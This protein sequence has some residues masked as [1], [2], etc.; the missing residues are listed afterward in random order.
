MYIADKDNQIKC[1]ICNKMWCF[2]L[3]PYSGSELKKLKPCQVPQ[4][5][6][7]TCSVCKSIKISQEST[8]TTSSSQD[9]S[10]T[11]KVDTSK[12]NPTSDVVPAQDSTKPE[13]TNQTSSIAGEKTTTSKTD[14]T[15][16]VSTTNA[17][18]TSNN[19]TTNS[20]STTTQPTPPNDKKDSTKK[21]KQKKSPKSKKIKRNLSYQ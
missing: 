14:A 21:R 5:G 1:G 2:I 20:A 18:L 12:L 8:T 15:T 6:I 19:N 16:S 10:K 17:S 11:D 3:E 13:T 7:P 4:R 9:Q